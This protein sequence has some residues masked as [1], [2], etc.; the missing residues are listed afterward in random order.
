MGG[1]GGLLK[2]NLDRVAPAGANR[3]LQLREVRTDHDGI[4]RAAAEPAG[5]D[6]SRPPAHRIQLLSAQPIETTME[7]PLAVYQTRLQGA[8][9]DWSAP[10]HKN[11]REFTGLAPGDYVF[12]ARR[13][14]RHGRA[15]A[16]V[17]YPFTVIAPWY[18]RWP[19]LTADA[20]ALILAGAGFVRWRL[21]LLRRQTVRLDR[22]VAQRTRELELSNTA[23]SEF[24]ENI[25]HEIRNPLN[26][27]VGLVN[28]LK[29]ER[30]GG[31]DQAV[32]R[33]LQA[34]A[35]H[36]RRVSEEVLGFS[37][38]EFGYVTVDEKPLS[39]GSALREVADLHAESARRLGGAVTLSLPAGE[40]RFVGDEAKIKTIV[41]NFVSNA[42]K[43]A[44][45]TPVAIR[46]EWTNEPD[47]EVVPVF[48]AVT[49]RGPGVPAN[50]QELI[51]QKF[52]RGSS[53]KQGGAVGSGIGLAI[54]RTL[55]IRMGGT[56]GVESPAAATVPGEEPQGSSF[57]LWLPLRRAAPAASAS[58][59]VPPPGP[60]KASP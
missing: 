22:L 52:V 26:G 51:F 5:R 29:P 30:L 36:L 37:K 45:A 48:I 10:E 13:V 41:G 12:M 9:S 11:T 40:D 18:Q 39:L 35:E 16:T 44:P 42:L 6:R 8:E 1:K 25:S 19:A 15:G 47:D 14:D 28:L 32:A 27:I 46:A 7:P 59:S 3:D 57:H 53:A 23:K 17:R 20:A 60:R 24:L 56:I 58:L 55:A 2:I 50:E 38:L 43:Y 34:S 21:R 33:S 49:D 4:A 31:E 54:C